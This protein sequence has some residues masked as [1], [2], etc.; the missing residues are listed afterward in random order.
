MGECD[1]T[2]SDKPS[3]FRSVQH[4]FYQQTLNGFSVWQERSGRGDTQQSQ[5]SATRPHY[6]PLGLPY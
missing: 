5:T 2:L 6:K 4:L 1:F 3:V